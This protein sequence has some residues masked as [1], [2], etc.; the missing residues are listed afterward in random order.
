MTLSIHQPNYLPWIGFIHKLMNSDIFI[1]FDDVQF[2]MGKN[3][4][5][6]R[7]KIR[8]NTGDMWLTLQ[9]NGKSSKRTWKDTT[10]SPSQCLPHH[11][12]CISQFYSKAS[13][14]SEIF[15]R[16]KNVYEEYLY[17]EV[18]PIVDF[19]TALI[20]EIC[21]ILKIETTIMRSSELDGLNSTLS[22][23][24]HIMDILRYVGATRYISGTGP[25][26]RRYIEEEN[27]KQS[28]IE[29]TWQS[30]NHPVYT[31]QFSP[32]YENLSIIDMLFNI[33]ISESQ[34]M[35]YAS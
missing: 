13:G 2:P 17:K 8:S 11:L 6:H 32:F 1:I 23:E 15:P 18:S 10:F 16:I 25:G 3:H 20:V 31:Q 4:F 28:G 30:F 29:L 21:D 24:E 22:G 27:F 34:K 5:G 12:E 9:V 19:N 7:T 14:Y 26:S 35:L 33:G